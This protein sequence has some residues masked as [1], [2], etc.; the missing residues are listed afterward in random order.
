MHPSPEELKFSRAESLIVETLRKGRPFDREFTGNDFS[1]LVRGGLSTYADALEQRRGV[2]LSIMDVKTPIREGRVLVTS[3]GQA[4][5]RVAPG[6]WT[7]SIAYE[8]SAGIRQ[9]TKP[10][11]LFVPDFD[12]EPD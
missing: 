11:R 6:I 9:D 5:K 12:F 1:M 10:G 8:L 7:P 4:Q 3:S 2:K